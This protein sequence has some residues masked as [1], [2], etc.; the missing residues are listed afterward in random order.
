MMDVSADR[1]H[2]T[3]ERNSVLRERYIHRVEEKAS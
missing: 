3:L 1:V 2:I